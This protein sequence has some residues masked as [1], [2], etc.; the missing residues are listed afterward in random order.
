[1]S[2][3]NLK[4][5]PT[6]RDMVSSLPCIF[7][8]LF[9]FDLFWEFDY[10]YFDVIA[11]NFNISLFSLIRILFIFKVIIQKTKK[12]LSFFTYILEDACLIR[13][14]KK[15]S[16]IDFVKKSQVICDGVLPYIESHN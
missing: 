4:G 11:K 15:E 3:K 14:E 6:D 16:K 12:I 10:S 2:G 1:M 7:F 5:K 13:K 8:I 9:N